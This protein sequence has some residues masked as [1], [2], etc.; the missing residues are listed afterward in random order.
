MLLAEKLPD[1]FAF[2]GAVRMPRTS[3]EALIGIAGHFHARLYATAP[4]NGVHA[5]GIL[6]AH[7][8][9][10]SAFLP[11]ARHMVRFRNLEVHCELHTDSAA[12]G[13]IITNPLD[14]FAVIEG[15]IHDLLGKPTPDG[16]PPRKEG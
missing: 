16:K 12:V 8:A 10:P 2:C 6:A 4:E 13:R 5:F 15:I 7:G 9:I 1:P 11:V 3:I 14:D